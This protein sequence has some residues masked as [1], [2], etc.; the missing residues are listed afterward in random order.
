MLVII[1]II[2]ISDLVC[3]IH[4]IYYQEFTFKMKSE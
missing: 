2:I 4:N 3:D 1:I